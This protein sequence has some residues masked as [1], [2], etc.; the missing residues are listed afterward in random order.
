MQNGVWGACP[1]ENLLRQPPLQCQ[2]T[3]FCGIKC[4]CSIIDLHAKK[5]KE[6]FQPGSDRI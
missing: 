1:Q 5:E 4:A 6:I 3:P 2:K